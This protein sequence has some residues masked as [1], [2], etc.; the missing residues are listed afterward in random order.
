MEW[1]DCE[2]LTEALVFAAARHRDQRRKDADRS[3]YIN[4]PIALLQVLLVEARIQGPPEVLIA[5]LLHDIL[6][7][8][9]TR[10]E[11]LAERFGAE[12]RDLVLELTDDKSLPKAE[13]KRLQIERAAGLSPKARLIA[14]ADKISNLRDLA[15]SPPPDWDLERRR[16]YFDWAAAAVEPLRGTHAELERLFDLA[17]SRRP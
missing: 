11:E 12:I 2:R 16:A 14:L 5:A 17:L 15:T 13:R 8:T 10:P 7:D 9:A 1:S 6:E 3:P 4:H